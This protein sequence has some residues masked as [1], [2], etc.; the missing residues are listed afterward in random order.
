MVYS[1]CKTVIALQE[2]FCKLDSTV[3]VL[4]LL[5]FFNF[6]VSLNI[7]LKKRNI[8][9]HRT[10]NQ[11]YFQFFLNSPHPSLLGI[12]KYILSFFYQHIL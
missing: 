11:F 2:M 7:K 10:E 4:M 12:Y 9:S 6:A 3:L 8:F 5:G 1:S